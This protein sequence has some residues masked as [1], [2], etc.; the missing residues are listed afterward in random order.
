MLSLEEILKELEDKT[1]LSRQELQEKINQKQT[2]LSGLVSLEG[3]GHLVA[4]DMGVNLLTVERKPVKIEN[5]SDGLKNVRVKG[6]ISDITPIRAFKR[7]DGTDG[8]VSNIIISDG[9]GQIRIPLWDKQ[10]DMIENNTISTGD[11]VE[12]SDGVVKKNMYGGLEVRMPKYSQMKKL[13]DD[14]SIPET[15]TTKTPL[16]KSDIKDIEEGFYEI[17]GNF[18]Q[19]F[20]TNT[21]IQLCPNCRSGLEKNDEGYSCKEHGKVKPENVMIISGIV[22]D[23]TS[24]IRA[25][26]FREQAQNFSGLEPTVLMNLSQ[27]EAFNLIKENVLGKDVALSGKVRKNT[28]FDNLE[29]VVNDVKELN[30]EQESKRLIIEMENYGG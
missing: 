18:V 28:M 14:S 6:R 30:V 12:V 19:L 15:A 11:I 20:N 22:D 23:G 8:K 7:K 3:A 9:S 10:V 25:V 26:F 29:M 2:E 1:K 21:V 4:R 24:S 16:K 17:Q 27:D 13:E 5:L